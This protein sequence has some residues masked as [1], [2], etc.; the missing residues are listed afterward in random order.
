MTL[1]FQA[2]HAASVT[3][4]ANGLTVLVQHDDRFPL[5]SLRLY[6]HAGSAYETAEQAGI[7]HLLEHMVFKGTEKRPK[8]G[9]AGD[10]EQ[11]GG[12]INAATSFDYTVYLTD[13]PADSWKLG[14]DVLKDMTFGAIIDPKALEPEIDVVLSELQR[15]ED[16]PGS[17]LFKQ[18]QAETLSGTPYERPI[19]GYRNTV[20]A[21]T[22]EDIHNYIKKYYQPQSM[23]LVVCGDV[24]T[25]EVIAEAESL[26]GNL[27]NTRAVNPPLPVVPV[28]TDAGATISV[29]SGEWNKVYAGFALPLPNFHDARMPAI[30]ALAQ[31]LGGDKTSL[32]YRTFK[33]D[34]MLVD[35][36]SV[37]AYAFE[38]TGMFF[39]TAVLDPE[40][41]DDFT[42][43]LADFFAKL[44]GDSF[45]D[46][47]INRA[48]LNLEDDLFRSKETLS[49]LASK[50]GYFQFFENGEQGERNY[51]QNLRH[52]NRP[53]LEEVIST[54]I[55]PEQ[56]RGMLLTPE[57]ATVNADQVTTRFAANWPSGATEAS[58]LTTKEHSGNKEVIELGNGRTVILIPDDTL[59]YTAIDL[60]FRGGDALL[61]P[62]DQGLAALTARTL[63]KGTRDL[64]NP[65]LESFKADRASS[66]T[67]S[68][69]RTSFTVSARFPERFS[70]DIIKLM[71]DIVTAPALAEEEAAREK[72]NQIAGIKAREDQPLGLAFRRLFP[73]LFKDSAYGYL[74]MGEPGRIAEFSRQQ[75]ASF[76]KNQSAQPWSLAVCGNFDREEVLAL[77]E[78]LPVPSAGRTTPA[79]PEWGADK[80]I[81]IP[82]KD[83]N[84][85]HMLMVFKT[86]PVTDED[87]PALELLQTVL[88]GQSG[89]LFSDLR[90]EQGLGYTVTS[91]PW[92]AEQAGLLAFYIGTEPE[93]LY[94]ADA[95]FR[96]VVTK[97]HN[98][99]LP[100]EAL[101]R[102]KNLLT[103]E[104]YRGRQTL[105]SRSNEAARLS[106]AMLPLDFEKEMVE[107][108]QLVDAKTLQAIARKYL[109]PDEAYIV[110]VLP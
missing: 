71:K 54:F 32:L 57:N 14:M 17:L 106:S 88:S 23:L 34:K 74:H 8:G 93:K 42:T 103:G 109:T 70:N 11:I 69:G 75:I 15:G 72:R 105:G 45:T 67:A 51:L 87:T 24:P 96:S 100:E 73:F 35:D 26:F 55:V 27:K 81:D 84:Q 48:K 66:L 89:L 68:A 13:V 102:A 41:I 110:R 43:Q 40:N 97:L 65:T 28:R 78:Q 59:P 33:Y 31:M 61:Q 49:G 64:D 22:A 85:A 12:N 91:F 38:R 83:R 63:T 90:D 5:A 86:V 29:K 44:N 36:I 50:L 101:N 99:L 53:A 47:A 46:E 76:W 2:A 30:E 98:E 79:A 4:L 104:Y 19:I 56:M 95:G 82:L 6:V 21:I 80:Q 62:E 39:I 25:E 1:P 18:L 108:A 7:S 10:I 60:S 94:L 37:S 9:V 77:A 92:Q 52:V 20:S 58:S 107:K 3:R 16:S